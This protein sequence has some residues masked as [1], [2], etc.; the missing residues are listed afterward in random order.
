MNRALEEIANDINEVETE[1]SLLEGYE[2]EYPEHYEQLR[3]R[4]EA[5][6]EE[7]AQASEAN[8][9]LTCEPASPEEEL[10]C[11]PPPDDEEN[12]CRVPA[13]VRGE[14]D[15]LWLSG[16]YADDGVLRVVWKVEHTWCSQAAKC[17]IEFSELSQSLP[18]TL[19][20]QEAND[21]FLY[22]TTEF[23]AERKLHEVTF[24][25]L[26]V[27]PQQKAGKY[28]TE[29]SVA[30]EANGVLS[31]K[32]LQVKH[33]VNFAAAE[34]SKDRAHFS[35]QLSERELRISRLIAFVK[36]WGGQVVKLGTS[37]DAGTGGLLDAEFT[38]S[39]YR[40]MKDNTFWD[41]AAWQPLPAGFV[42]DDSVHFGVGFYKSGADFVCQYGGKW[43]EA[44]T[45]FD[46]SAA[47]RQKKLA[48]WSATIAS[49]WTG[50]F[51][52]KRKEC[53]SVDS[54]CC[55][56]P[57]A[58][59]AAFSELAAF[60]SGALVIADGTGRSN[61]SLFFL[62]DPDLAM[63]AHEFGHHLGNPDEY[64]GA[65]V[66]TGM[67]GDGATNGIDPNSIMGQNMTTVKARHFGTI[68]THLSAVVKS[69][70]GVN[71]GYEPV[72]G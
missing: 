53:R 61:D 32:P 56:Y 50:Q 7:Y 18:V 68:C 26:D 19:K 51:F 34:Y 2:T 27:L 66:D 47:P 38:W 25:V 41:G 72:K 52:I 5:L 16:V 46:M 48:D 63:A 67:N 62:G 59:S 31:A 24:E 17:D 54:A 12:Q 69:T 3:L 70:H 10:V 37:V 55:R 15:H 44:F 36:G 22:Q 28:Q 58:A 20:F 11:E 6:V 43:P 71:F 29:T 42:L 9:S 8:G 13:P 21:A 40:W 35:L 65:A 33:V 30:A 64:A 1:L 39:G 60:V 23:A 57:T 14:G 4:H 45:D 49:T